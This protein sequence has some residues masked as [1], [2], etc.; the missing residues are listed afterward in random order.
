MGSITL[1][2]ALWIVARTL[3]VYLLLLLGV[4]F[5]GKREIGQMTPFD[6]VILLL[7]SNAVQNAMT[8]PDNSLAGGIVSAL[9]LLVAN[10][11]V[12]RLSYRIAPVRRFIDGMPVILVAHGEVSH[13]NLRHEGIT[14]DELMGAL[15]EHECERVDEVELATLEIDG[16][17]S[18]IRKTKGDNLHHTRKR[19]VRHSRKP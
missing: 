4:R 14:F 9:T 13:S 18:V 5:A 3:V 10:F 11:I 2:G 17:I 6:L 8:G 1:V 7:L 16:D 15:R 19:W 12:S